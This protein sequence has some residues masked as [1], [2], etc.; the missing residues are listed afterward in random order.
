MCVRERDRE[1]ER[2][3]PGVQRKGTANQLER[4]LQHPAGG[5][6]LGATARERPAGSAVVARVEE[7]QWDC[8]D[9]AEPRRPLEEVVVVPAHG[10]TRGDPHR[11]QRG[12]PGGKTNREGKK[13]GN[14]I[15]IEGDRSHTVAVGGAQH[16]VNHHEESTSCWLVLGLLCRT[17]DGSSTSKIKRSDKIRTII[18]H[19]P[20][21]RVARGPG[22]SAVRVE[23]RPVYGLTT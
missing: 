21:V 8:D 7:L 18:M 17:G 23:R 4:I 2:D 10:E 22:N 20:P 9:L 5:E 1:E 14:P 6:G 13:K 11:S 16:Q 15:R 19:A 3:Q 12:K